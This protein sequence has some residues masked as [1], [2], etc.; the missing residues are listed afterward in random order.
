MAENREQ[1]PMVEDWQHHWREKSRVFDLPIPGVVIDR[2]FDRLWI[3][4]C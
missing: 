4:C 2:L 3:L 1:E